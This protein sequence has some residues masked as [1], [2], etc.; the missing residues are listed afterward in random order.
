V[1]LRR[2]Y[3]MGNGRE[4][5]RDTDSTEL[6]LATLAQFGMLSSSIDSSDHSNLGIKARPLLISE[7]GVEMATNLLSGYARSDSPTTMISTASSDIINK[8]CDAANVS[9]HCHTLFRGG[10]DGSIE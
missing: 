7:S 1:V 9:A 10:A 5:L 3:P 6:E 4:H 2:N 8:L